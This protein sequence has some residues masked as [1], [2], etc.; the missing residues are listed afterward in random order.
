MA[1]RRA[2]KELDGDLFS[3]LSHPIRGRIVRDSAE[4]FSPKMLFDRWNG[5]LSI[6]LIA[7]HVRQLA[8]KDL[9]QLDS[10][11]PRRGAVEHFYRASPTV[12]KRLRE[13]SKSFDALASQLEAK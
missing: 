10:T 9:L 4:P 2:P 6:Q 13:A 3:A 12:V 5:E 7:Y 1:S 8:D 11:R